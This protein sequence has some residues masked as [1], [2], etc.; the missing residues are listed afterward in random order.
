MRGEFGERERAEAEVGGEAGGVREGGGGG[1][2]RVEGEA[3][4]CWRERGAEDFEMTVRE[5]G[6][7]EERERESS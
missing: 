3:L 7:G 4:H 5:E 2:G 6:R 1:G